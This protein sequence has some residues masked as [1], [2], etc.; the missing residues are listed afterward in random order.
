MRHL[1]ILSSVFGLS[2]GLL[3]LAFTQSCGS[4]YSPLASGGQASGG[5]CSETNGL[6]SDMEAGDYFTGLCTTWKIGIGDPTGTSTVVTRF[7]AGSPLAGGTPG[8]SMRFYGTLVCCDWQDAVTMSVPLP[9]DF[10]IDV[11]APIGR[12]VFSM[13]VSADGVNRL[14]PVSFAHKNLDWSFYGFAVKPTNTNWNEYTIYLPG[15]GTGPYIDGFPYGGCVGKTKG[16]EFAK[17][18]WGVNAPQDDWSTGET[19]KA[20]LTELKFGPPILTVPGNIN[21]DIYLDDIRF[22]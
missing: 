16:N 2:L 10:N 1:R 12:L 14:H 19:I 8:K 5:G 15:K 9:E 3:G 21:F 4:V 20:T 11:N 6:I 22:E 18:C 7:E 17:P 13:K